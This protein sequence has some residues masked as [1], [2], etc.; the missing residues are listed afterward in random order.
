MVELEG[1]TL[2]SSAGGLVVAASTASLRGCV[3]RGGRWGLVVGTLLGPEGTGDCFSSGGASCSSYRPVL[4]G[5]GGG[6]CGVTVRTLRTAQWTR[7]SSKIFLLGMYLDIRADPRRAGSGRSSVWGVAGA[8]G[9]WVGVGVCVVKL[10]RAH[11]GCL[12][13][14]SR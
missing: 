4:L 8:G 7:A 5:S 6:G 12:G 10:L 3:E 14:R 11:G 1:G 13:T 2:T 9:W